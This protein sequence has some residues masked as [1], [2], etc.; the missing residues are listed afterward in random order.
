MIAFPTYF[1][2][3]LKSS[4]LCR[5]I[6]NGSPWFQNLNCNSLLITDELIFSRKVSGILF[7]SGQHGLQEQR[8]KIRKHYMK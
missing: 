5:R 4:L 6:A 2:L 7:V 1:F 8:L 3:S